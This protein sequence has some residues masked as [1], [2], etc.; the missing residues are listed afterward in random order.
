MK[1]IK[2]NDFLKI[3]HEVIDKNLNRFHELIIPLFN[4]K[5]YCYSMNFVFSDELGKYYS[6]RMKCVN[7]G[8]HDWEVIVADGEEPQD[9]PDFVVYD[10]KEEFKNRYNEIANQTKFCIK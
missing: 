6:F 5:G 3:Q 9:T 10:N 8:Y 4:K 1:L 7:D 2:W